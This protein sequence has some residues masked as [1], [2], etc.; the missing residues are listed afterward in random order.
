M[1][2]GGR[3]CRETSSA[4]ALRRALV[5]IPT[6]RPDVDES[7]D[8]EERPSS[9]ASRDPASLVFIACRR[10]GEA[11]T[12]ANAVRDVSGRPVCWNCGLSSLEG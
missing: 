12:L 6:S 11:V 7:P 3:S 5:K 9:A 2:E 4:L 8:S 1:R 10:C